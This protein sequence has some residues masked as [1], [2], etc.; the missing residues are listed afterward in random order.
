[1]K[2]KTKHQLVLASA[3]PRRKE[4]FS[5]L[6]VPFEVIPSSVEETGVHASDFKDYVQKVALL[7]TKDVATNCPG[8][9]VIGADTIVV[10]NNELLHKPKTPEEA[11][12]HLEKLSSNRHQVMTAVAIITKDRQAESFVEVTDVY[13]KNLPRKLIEKYVETKDP[14][15]K[16]GGYGIQ[17]GGALFIDRIEGDY[18]TV[19]G[20][21]IASL[22][23]KLVELDIIEL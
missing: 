2:F 19:V 12:R 10:F 7:K 16:A 5:K 22:F 14:F 21:P 3:S 17:T 8:K 15:D 11:I 9:T 4:L 1:M 13:F 18:N 6:G 23:E 20:L